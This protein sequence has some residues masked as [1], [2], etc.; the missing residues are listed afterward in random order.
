L[1]F[2]FEAKNEDMSSGERV[3][4]AKTKRRASGQDCLRIDGLDVRLG[5][6]TDG[7]EKRIRH[8]LALC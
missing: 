7:S 5:I 2:V 8:R 3:G 4:L 6:L 1:L